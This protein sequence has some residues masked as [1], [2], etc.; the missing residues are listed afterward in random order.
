M[1]LRYQE[2]TKEV[3]AISEKLAEIKSTI[4]RCFPVD[5]VQHTVLVL[6]HASAS[7]TRN[8]KTLKSVLKLIPTNSDFLTIW[9]SPDVGNQAVEFSQYITFP[10]AP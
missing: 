5:A 10:I 1:E 6:D 9:I 8:A 4:E 7:L 3:R 2:F